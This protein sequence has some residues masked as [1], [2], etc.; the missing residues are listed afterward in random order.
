MGYFFIS[1]DKIT[2]WTEDACRRLGFQLNNFDA[3]VEYTEA[4]QKYGTLTGNH[5]LLVIDKFFQYVQFC[6]GHDVDELFTQ[7][8]VTLHIVVL[9]YVS[10]FEVYL[11]VPKAPPYFV[12]RNA[13]T[14]LSKEE[15][16]KNRTV[17]S[18][19]WI[20]GRVESMRTVEDLVNVIS[21]IIPHGKDA[22]VSA[23][24]RSTICQS[25]KTAF[26]RYD[27]NQFQGSKYCQWLGG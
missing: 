13:Q 10:H 14:R 24:N 12:V 16:T 7:R 23:T 2:F 26:G 21:N 27:W 8:E 18:S 17:E 19:R 6:H 5:L 20:V 4:A 1:D 11:V 3:S 22:S 25:I 15:D 9:S